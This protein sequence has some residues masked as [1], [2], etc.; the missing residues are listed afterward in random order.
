MKYVFRICLLLPFAAFNATGAMSQAAARRIEIHA[1][2]F[3]FV[4]AEITVNK[5]EPVTLSLTSE[6]VTHALLIPGLNINA[7]AS[8]GHV[9]EVT[10]TPDKAGDFRGKCGRFCGSGHGSMLFVVHVTDK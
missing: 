5:N 3:S 7:T 10:F 2:R 1:K 6:D 4:P 8:K 9:T